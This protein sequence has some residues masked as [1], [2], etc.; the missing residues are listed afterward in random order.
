M[1]HDSTDKFKLAIRCVDA[2]QN[3]VEHL[4]DL[5]NYDREITFK[6]FAKHVDWKPIAEQMGYV[7]TKGKQEGL[8]LVHD[9]CVKFYKSV[10]KGTPCYHMDHSSVDFVFLKQETNNMPKLS[11]IWS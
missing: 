10:W 9:Y 4:N 5:Y 2:P 7:T 3:E 1:K 6:T 11:S 8:R